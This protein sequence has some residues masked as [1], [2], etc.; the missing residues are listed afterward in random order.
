VVDGVRF[1][2]MVWFVGLKCCELWCIKKR[3]KEVVCGK[4]LWVMGYNCNRSGYYGG[5]E[6]EKE[7]GKGRKEGYVARN[8][9]GNVNLIGREVSIVGL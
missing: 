6:R 2:A 4:G 9:V 8:L 5:R 1:V 3:T 7:I